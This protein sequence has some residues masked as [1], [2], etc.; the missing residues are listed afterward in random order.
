VRNNKRYCLLL[1]GFLS[2]LFSLSVACTPAGFTTYSN[3]QFGYSV[4]YPMNWKAE[5]SADGTKCLLL[6]PTRQG[7]VM[8]DVTDAMSTR[9]AANYLLMSIAQGTPSKEVSKLEDKPM[10]GFWDWYL[11]YDYETDFDVFHGEAYFKVT[12]THL[13][14]LDTASKVGTYE[15]YPFSKIISSF[16]LR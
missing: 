12:E 6:S 10:E 4:S 16:K 7:S 8:I 13:Y 9:V 3:E 5:A 11:S 14:K 2:L 1:L 15:D